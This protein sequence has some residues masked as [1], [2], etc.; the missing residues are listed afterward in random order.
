MLHIPKEVVLGRSLP[1]MHRR[2]SSSSYSSSDSDEDDDEDDQQETISIIHSNRNS[3][4]S[5]STHHHSNHNRA[6]H[7]PSNKSSR[8]SNQIEVQPNVL[9]AN[10]NHHHHCYHH[11]HHRNHSHVT[12][13]LLLGNNKQNFD[14]DNSFDFNGNHNDVQI[15]KQGAKV[16]YHGNQHMLFQ[17]MKSGN[18]QHHGFHGNHDF[19]SDH[20]NQRRGSLPLSYVHAVRSHGFSSRR[21][22]D[23]DSNMSSQSLPYSAIRQTAIGWDNSQSS[24]VNLESLADANLPSYELQPLPS[25]RTIS[26]NLPSSSDLDRSQKLLA[27]CQILGGSKSVPNMDVTI[28]DIENFNP[29]AKSIRQVK[30]DVHSACY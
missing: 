10:G 29:G 16:G 28:P 14:S 11:H 9:V 27:Q 19:L 17:H 3:L 1:S 12:H 21:V 22:G 8:H 4:H 20:D 7:F 6:T 23:I 13:P 30:V 25:Q 24:S 15:R 5:N 18:C 26:V 2:S